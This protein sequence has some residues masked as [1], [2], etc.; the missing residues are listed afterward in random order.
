MGTWSH[1]AYFSAFPPPGFIVW[2]PARPWVIPRQVLSL[3]KHLPSFQQE[4]PGDGPGVCIPS[5]VLV[6]ARKLLF[7]DCEILTLD[8]WSRC[9]PGGYHCVKLQLLKWPLINFQGPRMPSIATRILNPEFWVHS[10]AMVGGHRLVFSE[11]TEFDSSS[12][13]MTFPCYFR[14]WNTCCVPLLFHSEHKLPHLL[15]ESPETLG[16]S[17]C[18]TF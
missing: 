7:H 10:E 1:W 6:P 15:P 16:P 12:S 5:I 2:I 17:S 9:F 4:S 13:V 18:L 3:E 8:W 14:L 11:T